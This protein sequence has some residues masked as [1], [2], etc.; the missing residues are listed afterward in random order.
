M[1]AII[2]Y[3]L[4]MDDGFLEVVGF[5]K[6]ESYCDSSYV[7]P[8]YFV[9]FDGG[10]RGSSTVFGGGRGGKVP[11]YVGCSGDERNIVEVDYFECE[12][13]LWL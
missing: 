10:L 6:S 2:L 1:R 12:L 13:E 11:F 7:V 9:L 3:Y 5:V 8:R 4:E